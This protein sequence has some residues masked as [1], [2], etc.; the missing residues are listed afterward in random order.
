[1]PKRE[2]RPIIWECWGDPSGQIPNLMFASK[3]D[4]GELEPWL[5]PDEVGVLVPLYSVR[6]MTWEEAMQA[7]YDIQEWGRYSPMENSRG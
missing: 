1:M 3:C 2:R 4:D 7:H 6:A 5:M